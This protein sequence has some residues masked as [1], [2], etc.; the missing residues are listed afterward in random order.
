MVPMRLGRRLALPVAALAVVA[1]TLTGCALIDLVSGSTIEEA[2]E[3]LPA[4]TFELRFAD[5]G[6]MAERLEIDDLDPRE[7]SEGALDD[8][9]GALEEERDDEM[10]AVA[11]TEL[12]DYVITMKDAP[13]NDL[14]VEWE[15]YA[16]WGD[17]PD[18]PAREAFVW[19][20]GDAVDFGSLADD[21]EDKGYVEVRSDEFALYSIDPA[22][23]DDANLI[24]G[25]YPVV[26]ASVLID[27]DEQVVVVSFAPE[28]LDDIARVI[29]DDADSLADDGEI[30]DLLDAANDDAEIAWLTTAGPSLCSDTEPPVPDDRRALYDDLGQPS[31]RAIFIPG[32]EAPAELVLEFDDEDAAE[33][34]QAARE[35]L[36]DNGVDALSLRPF[37]DLGDFDVRRDGTLVVIEEDFDSGSQAA[38]DA[39]THGIGPGFCLD[40]DD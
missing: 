28:P 19:K 34:D 1:P 10:A 29:A 3:Y 20:I 6:A 39:E 17:D 31:A 24:D 27:E 12:T 33:D 16:S 26:M 36:V 8:Y 11:D 23:I 32:D 22:R 35:A 40:E 9:L 18:K 15:A 13:L 14:D 5:R 7:A 21:L 30:D 2:F 25:V 38:L 37:S 4:N